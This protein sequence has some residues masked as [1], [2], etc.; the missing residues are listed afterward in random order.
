MTVKVIVGTQW[1]DE[2]KGKITD[3]LA[4]KMEL[5]IRY[6]GGNN[7]GHTVVVGNETFKLHL[8]PSGILYNNCTC[9]I[10]NGV[11]LD[12]EVFF[13]EIETLAKQNVII[14]PK[15][16]NVSCN[17]HIILPFHKQLDSK[18]E[19]KR[20]EEK[21][22]TTGKGIGPTYADKTA[23]RGIRVQDLL[24]PKNFKK[25]LEKQQWEQHLPNITKADIEN[26][27]NHYLKL[28]KKLKPF[29][30][31]TSLTI[32]EAINEGKNILLEGAQGTMLDIDHGS[33]PYVTSS[34]PTSGGACIGAGIGPNK[35][36]GVIGVTKAYVTRVGEGP[37]PTEQ[38]NQ[39]G[40][41]LQERGA[42]F[43]TTTGRIRRC[44]WLDLVILRYAIRINGITEICLTK[45]DVLD[46]METI[47]VCTGYKTQ[48]GIINEF[49]QDLETF[50]NCSPIYE[51]LP[52]W[53]TDIST[54][55]S[56]QDLPKNAKAY[57]QYIEKKV[58]VEIT[59]VSVGSKRRQTIHLLRV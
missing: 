26:I 21:I 5:V 52:G 29:I 50:T 59:M 12:P 54:L 58:G 55:T 48:D 4:E 8:I 38:E 35:I 3:I 20:Y 37:F 57:I 19:A 14:T 30:C 53:K 44:G 41:H 11:V 36:S 32:N 9:I 40:K 18:Q 13:Q 39:I 33:Y 1:G 7:A 56:Y 31:D 2:G 15:Q 27:Y 6:Q 28:G 10:G 46:H 47:Q 42:E 49:P 45:L 17:A 16:L 22:G 34:N 25:K 51:S 43:G 23:R 24:S